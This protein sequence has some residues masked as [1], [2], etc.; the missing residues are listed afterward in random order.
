MLVSFFA[1]LPSCAYEHC[2]GGHVDNLDVVAGLDSACVF[3][4]AEMWQSH[5]GSPGLFLFFFFVEI[6]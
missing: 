3:K 4:R 2:L 5:S 6:D 1:R